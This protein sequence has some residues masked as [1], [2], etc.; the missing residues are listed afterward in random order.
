MMI[1]EPSDA[2]INLLRGDAF[3][4]ATSTAAA[5]VWILQQQ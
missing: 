2:T 4:R 5:I 3:H 1:P